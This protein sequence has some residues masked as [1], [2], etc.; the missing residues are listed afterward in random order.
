MRF[1]G[2]S[3]GVPI[4]TAVALANEVLTDAWFNVP[5]M[6]SD[7]YITQMAALVHKRLGGTH[8]AYIEFS[9]EVWNGA[10]SQSGYATSQGQ[11]TFPAG[12]RLAAGLQPQLVWN[13]NS[14][15]V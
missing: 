12:T 10:F 2:T 8:R 6:A 14:P 11:A 3:S 4:E 1:W 13:E 7:D 5:V 9:N 15:D